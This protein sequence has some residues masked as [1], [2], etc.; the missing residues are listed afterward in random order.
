[1][2][3]R[4]HASF[5]S[6]GD[7]VIFYD[8][9]KNMLVAENPL[10]TRACTRPTSAKK[11]TSESLAASVFKVEPLQNNA[12]QRALELFLGGNDIDS[13]RC[14]GSPE[15]VA[16]LDLLI[17]NAEKERV[18]NQTE[19]HRLIGK[20]VVY[21]Q[22]IQLYNAHFNKYLAITGRTCDN[23]V[24]H[25]QV[26]LS[27]D[28]VG[29][30]GSF[31][32]VPR[33]RIRVDGEPVRIED[34]FAIQCVRPE[35]YLNADTVLTH[36][37]VYNT[38]Y[39]EVYSYTRISSWTL[40]LHSPAPRHDQNL[41]SKY[42][43]SAQYI[44]FYHKEIEGYLESDH[45]VRLKRHVLNPLDPKE[46]D[47]PLA[48][49]EIE[50]A[51]GSKGSMVCWNKS[52]RIRH[53]A[54]RAYLYID[55]N[56]V[57]IN[58]VSQKVSF[59]LGLSKEPAVSDH[60]DPTLF[61]IVPASDQASRGVP[62]GSYIRIQH[63]AT[64]CWLHA[65]SSNEGDQSPP[66]LPSS[67]SL[68]GNS[69]SP[70]SAL[71]P[72]PTTFDVLSSAFGRR[73]SNNSM[74]GPRPP[75]FDTH[76]DDS[77][78]HRSIHSMRFST[79]DALH[80]ASALASAVH[81]VTATQ[82]FYYHDC[83]TVTVASDHLAEAFN[84]VNEY[85]PRLY[86]F[87][88]KRRRPDMHSGFP[89]S[90]HEF[91]S[92]STILINLIRFCTKSSENDVTQRCGLPIPYHQSM[93][94]E[95]GVIEAVI[96]LI[97][98]P[99]SIA[100]RRK[101]RK[102]IL[103]GSTH[104]G[105]D[106]LAID[107]EQMAVLHA[108]DP[109]QEY[110]LKVI[111]T[112]CYNL[113]RVFLLP[114]S[115]YEEQAELKRNQEYVA[116][117]AGDSGLQLF[118]DHLDCGIG[119]A[120][121]LINLIQGNGDIVQKLVDARPDM[122]E[123]L[124]KCSIL[125]CE[126]A[127]HCM[128]TKQQ[129]QDQ[130][131]QPI[132]PE[133][134]MQDEPESLSD[135][136]SSTSTPSPPTSKKRSTIMHHH[137]QSYVVTPDMME[138]PEFGACLDLLGIVCQS[139]TTS[140]AMTFSHRDYALEQL[141]DPTASAAAAPLIQCRLDQ[142]SGAVEIQLMRREQWLD[143][144]ALMLD[145][146]SVITVFLAKLLNLV[147]SLSRHTS[148]SKSLKLL[149]DIFS[150]DI[151]LKSLGYLGLPSQIRAVFCNLL[152]ELHVKAS[153][154]REV[155]LSDFTMQYDLL[156]GSSLYPR[157]DH[158]DDQH[159]D[160]FERL[161]HWTMVFLDD[162]LHVLT[163]DTHDVAL[164]SSVL[165]LVSIQLK[166]GYFTAP[167]DVKRLFRSLVDVLDG[168]TD[169]KNTEHLTYMQAYKDTATWP[170]RFLHTETNQ[171]SMNIKIQ[172]L[173]IL[174]LIFD[175]R[176]HVRMNKLAAKWKQ[177]ETNLDMD[178]LFSLRNVLTNI[179]A[180]TML[181]HRESGLM[182]I[183]KDILKYQY[184]PLK[185]VG[186]RVMHRMYHDSEDL[187]NKSSQVLILYQPQHVFVYHGIK[188]RLARLRSQLVSEKL[189]QEHLP[190]VSR[191]LHEFLSLLN[192]NTIDYDDQLVVLE[193]DEAS[194][195][196]DLDKAVHCNL[197]TRTFMN[198]NVHQEVIR[199]LDLL[200]HSNSNTNVPFSDVIRLCMQLL[201]KLV[202]DDEKL[203]GAFILQHLD[204]LIDASSHDAS[205]SSLLNVICGS[206]LYI[207]LRISEAHI[208]RILELSQGLDVHYLRLLQSFMKVND[209]LI[210]RNQDTIMRIIMDDRQLYVPFNNIDDLLKTD[211]LDYCLELIELLS[212]CGHGENT[213]GQS[214]ART[215]F[216]VEEVVQLV[217]SH[218][219]PLPIKIKTL[220]FLTSIY[221]D[222]GDISASSMS[223]DVNTDL[224]NLMVYFHQVLLQSIT[225]NLTD[226]TQASFAAY[227]F[228]GVLVVLRSIFEYHVKQESVWDLALFDLCNDLTD[229]TIALLPDLSEPV[230]PHPNLLA[231]IDSM[232]NVSGF[233]GSANAATLR[234]QLQVLAARSLDIDKNDYRHQLGPI[235]TKFQGF[236]RTLKAHRS[237]LQLQEE[238]FKQ[239]GSHYN[240]S[241]PESEIDVQSL[242][243]FLSMM[244]HSK[245]SSDEKN[246]YYQVATMRLLQEIPER[247]IR[248]RTE[249]M[250]IKKQQASDV[251]VDELERLKIN[252]QNTLSRLGCTLVAQNLLSSPRRQVFRASLT[253]LIALLDGGNK[254][255]Q[256][257]LEEYFYSIREERFFYSFHRRLQTDI[258][259]LKEA[260]LHITRMASK[261]H[262]Q[263]LLLDVN[264]STTHA[265]VPV[266]AQQLRAHKRANS[267]ILPHVMDQQRSALSI[268]MD[269][270][271]RSNRST[272]RL[273]EAHK[274]PAASKASMS[275]FMSSEISDLGASAEEFDTMKN[276][277]RAVQLMVE[278]HN[279][280]LQTYL[281]KQ[282]DNIKS[283][284]IVQDIVDYLH[285]IAP[286]CN[287]QNIR[288]IIQ[289]LDT[290][291][292]LAQ[293]CLE[294]QLT[295]YNGKIVHPV[296]AILAETYDNCPR[297]LIQEVKSKVVIC[298]LSLLEG[299][300]ENSETIF[301]EM[302]STL[303]LATVVNNMNT[304]Y[305]ANLQYIDSPD[306]Y[307]KMESG[308][309]Y[310]MLI[311]TLSP[312]LDA[313]QRKL[314]IDNDAYHYFQN[315][316]GKIEVVM[317]YG[318][319]KQLSRVLFPI[320]DVCKYFRE[321]TKERFLWN[322]KRDSPSTKI[323]DF[324]EQSSIMIYE[325]ENQA[326]V[327]YNEHLSILTQYSSLWWKASF[328]VTILLN[329][330]MLNC[331]YILHIDGDSCPTV[332]S[333]TRVF[334]G[335]LHLVL[336]H[337]STAEFYF[338]QLPVLVK[339]R[340]RSKLSLDHTH[341]DEPSSSLGSFFSEEHLKG[342]FLMA[343]LM[344]VQ[345]VYH[346]GM[347]LLSYLG[348]WYPGFYSVHLLD[349]V[350]RDQILQGVIASITLN[351]SSITHTALLAIVVIYLHSVMAY[352]YFHGDFDTSKGLY[353]RSLSEC[354]VNVL[355]H[356]LRG[357]I[358]DVFLESDGQDDVNRGWRI[359]FE[360]S[361]YLVV[362]VFL[363]NAIFGIIF[364][365]FGHLRDERSSVQ[366]DMK[367]SCFICSIP[368]VEFQRHAKR[369]FDDHVKNDHN[370]WQY[371]FFLVHL[372]YKDETEYTGPESYV[373]GCL[374][375]SNYSFF[376]I[377]RA[378]CLRQ[379]ESNDSERLEK[380]DEMAQTLLTRLTK[381]ESQMD[382]LS[383]SQSRSR[384]NSILLSPLSP[385]I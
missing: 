215:V 140:G 84:F 237:V 278:G 41:K 311:M 66:H 116:D 143:L 48:F 70:S 56:N 321:D 100:K 350:F 370:I 5:L 127:A 7:E 214:F 292:E 114:V 377:N 22:V 46:S 224:R 201:T 204:L 252:A 96:R 312:A 260:Q 29:V 317:E 191:I 378:L 6:I 15:V 85:L 232:I 161:K 344:E 76:H 265:L 35:G 219:T 152:R 163:E 45:D 347:V 236:I 348:L 355:T 335:L 314:L 310:C 339:R 304:I 8:E 239:L 291:T 205:L 289:V 245:E 290:I 207:S 376:P 119:A 308:F 263:Q 349:F 59:S 11:L 212:I 240:L 281:A 25:L 155:L 181:R 274:R 9:G 315:N 149:R 307:T 61:T 343:S 176:V 279:I 280:R 217:K 27:N 229:V 228:D 148:N 258:S 241:G 32:I 231:C 21:G 49:W 94:C 202:H 364:D 324:V 286:L 183:L 259:S 14:E 322:V 40:S 198:L 43:H 221:L 42:I 369:G 238:E 196:T 385:S 131:E 118:L 275:S 276:A 342:T 74:H 337:L 112:L 139:D 144:D 313:Q 185:Q 83:F 51:D 20:P 26:N 99:F 306:A 223:M 254:N 334:F 82:D 361:F 24:S 296:N 89:I 126:T 170:E 253:L 133:D 18:Q 226:S 102:A 10:A 332:N 146:S 300:I 200:C 371:L 320:P 107:S 173:E 157:G 363:L 354:F 77:H 169:A 213:Y 33:Y 374:K 93:L 97:Q 110:R 251:D 220:R 379:N 382:K 81:S 186:V 165:Q 323:E 137:Q 153:P 372:K 341:I 233:H 269:A 13:L 50:P 189:G 266:K 261:L 209:K 336:W 248:M 166:L 72:Q 373:A 234:H 17:A 340:S 227:I 267:M 104:D 28:I 243:D 172:I 288:L 109:D 271:F 36:S 273:V 135:Q 111:L 68:I 352:K 333:V 358:G 130:K 235:N 78:R 206:S 103:R 162:H 195:M 192:G 293:G 383:E 160:L 356:G 159:L 359:G 4:H 184:A 115:D 113:L 365:T 91:D 188:K 52:V 247:F 158:A 105:D 366:Q 298:L 187:F 79:A 318:Q 117:V 62:F 132:L 277:M 193:S 121:M 330:L 134:A 34:T 182:P 284:N 362:V 12:E 47:S 101:V 73:L 255:V 16:Q 319:E 222:I 120:P 272:N 58:V 178:P 380:L 249:H 168:R 87:M 262:R 264:Q 80:S 282:P 142:M 31:R 381:L 360:M 244:T 295:I 122:L 57:S 270:A 67:G 88:K 305:Q 156:E 297:V 294:N 283:F 242:I 346:V 167:D 129:K 175:L 44:R 190:L 106:G 60:N 154:H 86:D 98:I 147:C 256:D 225:R 75:S 55:P 246:E 54:S 124:V 353:C 30:G 384:S 136:G 2:A 108:S 69:L 64:R 328:A 125:Q 39:Y 19:K 92:V 141:F 285:A 23:D 230:R 1:M 329:L 164:L 63:S 53:A 367:N 65:T 351:G 331:S 326:R 208:K 302:A 257:Q 3:S 375:E 299:G 216:T 171:P 179:F 37:T 303:D 301:R 345:F 151:C 128:Y 325:V 90:Q 95:N 327:T 150:Q 145:S 71:S 316:T 138:H 309:L 180:D 268:N 199:I 287:I 197:Y 357:G 194:P 211:R 203:Q 338:I 123:V 218:H 250:K 177:M 210:K 368:A 38:D 174:D